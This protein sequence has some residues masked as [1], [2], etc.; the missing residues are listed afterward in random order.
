MS[1]GEAGHQADFSHKEQLKAGGEHENQRER[2]HAI[3]FD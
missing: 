1:R 2:K 3:D